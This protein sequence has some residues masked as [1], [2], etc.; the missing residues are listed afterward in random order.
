MGQPLGR[1]WPVVAVATAGVLLR[2]VGFPSALW[3]CRVFIQKIIVVMCV[4]YNIDVS[5]ASVLL[6][7]HQLD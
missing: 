6:V 7:L 5:D 4:G 1:R 3:D 2:P